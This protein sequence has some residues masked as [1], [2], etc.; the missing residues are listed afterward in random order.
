MSWQRRI[1]F[2]FLLAG[3]AAQAP[4]DPPQLT[5]LGPL[6]AGARTL[7]LQADGSIW[8]GDKVLGG[9]GSDRVRPARRAS[10]A[11]SEEIEKSE[12]GT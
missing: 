7:T 3:L 11:G 4:I 9:R 12:S 10:G 5:R 8:L 6:V 1:P 2:A